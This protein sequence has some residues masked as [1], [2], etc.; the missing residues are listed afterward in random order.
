MMGNTGHKNRYESA[1][2][3]L[4]RCRNYLLV[5]AKSPQ[6]LCHSAVQNQPLDRQI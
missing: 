5:A 3:V 6:S 4:A 1:Q 2:Q